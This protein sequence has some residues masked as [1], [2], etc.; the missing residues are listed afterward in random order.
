M[1]IIIVG[2]GISG[3]ATYL[4]LKKNLPASAGPYDITI[5]ESHRP[6]KAN[7]ALAADL[8]FEEL[9]SS[10]LL[11]GGGLAVGANGMRV[12]RDLDPELHDKLKAQ[13]FLVENFVFKAARGWRLSSVPT[14]DQREVQEWPV[15]SSRHGV[16]KTFKEAVPQ[17]RV[18][19]RKV[20]EVF[21][22]ESGKPAVKFADGDQVEEADLVIGADGVRSVVKRG[23]FKDENETQ[24]APV[25][26]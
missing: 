16:W 18:V 4:F 15:A 9:S 24:F 8:N 3:L 7:E 13:G 26:E 11:V 5:Y 25:Y 14:G 23:L 1:K 22:S 21:V 20:V 6:R 10:T 12:V 17:D 2:A 19:Y